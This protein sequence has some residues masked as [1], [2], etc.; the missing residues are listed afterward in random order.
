M[1]LYESVLREDLIEIIQWTSD[2]SPRSLQ[3]TLGCSEAGSACDRKIAY[4]IAGKPKINFPD[5]LKALM[6]TAFHHLLD[7]NTV[8]FQKV[9][10]TSEWLTETEVW[11]AKFLKGHVDLYS[12]KRKLVLDWKTSSA[13]M[14]KK[15]QVDGIPDNYKTQIMLYGKGMV[16][17][18]HEVQRVGLAAVPRGGTLRDILVLTVAY[19]PEYANAALTRVWQIGKDLNSGT[20]IGDITAV[21][22]FMEC[23]YCPYYRGGTKPA[24]D[25]GCPGKLLTGDPVGDL[26]N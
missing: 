15:W 25:A 26:F 21:P 3:V 20:P 22:S 8:E 17:A 7:I 19:D 16:N 2:S 12:T 11:P 5:P 18:G 23:S 14:I 9:Q 13:D 4:R 10:G 6:G 24:D 1:T